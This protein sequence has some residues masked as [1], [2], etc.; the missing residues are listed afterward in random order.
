MPPSAPAPLPP[1]GAFILALLGLFAWRQYRVHVLGLSD[2]FKNSDAWS[3]ATGSTNLQGSKI[4]E[5]V[6]EGLSLGM[7]LGAGSFGR[8]YQGGRGCC[9]GLLRTA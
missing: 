6:P 3:R 5:Q 7:L 9:L 4:N 1:A 2:P 8:V